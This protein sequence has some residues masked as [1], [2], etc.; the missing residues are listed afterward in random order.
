LYSAAPTGVP[1]SI[2]YTVRTMSG[3]Q[4][5][6]ATITVIKPLPSPITAANTGESY[7]HGGQ[8][9]ADNPFDTNWSVNLMDFVTTT[10]TGTLLA[11]TIDLN[12][13]L[14][15]IQ[16]SATEL[17]TTFTVDSNGIVTM[18]APTGP[19]A[20]PDTGFSY[21]IQDSDGYTSN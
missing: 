16:S 12:P 6:P 2:Q 8:N 1:I 21:T 11:S 9:C 10:G 15:G 18:T 4:L 20:H 17:G 5:S 14:P 19:G 3:V 13:L 7:M